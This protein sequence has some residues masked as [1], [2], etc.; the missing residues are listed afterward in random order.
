MASKIQRRDHR[1]ALD[2]ED[3]SA[4]TE[5]S[6]LLASL[7]R[8]ES[9]AARSLASRLTKR[10]PR[11]GVPWKVLGALLW[12]E[13]RVPEALAAM[14]KSA[15]LLP[16]DAEAL[17]NLGTSLSKLDRFQEAEAR[18]REAID[19][20]PTFATAHYRLGMN[21]SLQGLLPEAVT[22]LRTG[23]ALRSRYA[24]GDDAQ[25]HSNLLFILS[26]LHS[27]HPQK[28]FEEHCGFAD[29]FE[30]RAAW[31][32]HANDR[33]AGRRLKIGFVSG[34]FREHAVSYFFQPVVAH[35]ATSSHVELHAY[36]NSAVVDAVTCRL[37][38]HFRHW[39]DV[40][41][42]TDTE[43]ADRIV[44]DRIDIL[45]D[46]AGHTSLNRL[47]VFARKPAPLQISWI[48]YPGTT[49]L[50]AM[51]YY[52]ADRHWLPAARFSRSF[53]EKLAYLPDRWAF[54]PH[55]EAP[56]VSTLPALASGRL[57]FG[58]FNRAEKIG[59]ATVL[60]WSRLLR[61]MP[62]TR[63]VVGGIRLESQR[64]A[65][66][67]AF[68]AAGIAA[69]RLT[70]HRPGNMSTHL[71][72]HRLVDLCLDTTP[73]NGGTTTLHALSMGV[74]TLTLAGDTPMAH[75]GAGILENLQLGA[76]VAADTD[77]FLAK[78]RY[79]SDHLDELAAIRLGMRARLR[80]S[81]VGR[82]DL[83]ASHVEGALRHMWTRWC[84]NLP[85]ESFDSSA[86][87]P[88]G[89]MAPVPTDASKLDAACAKAMELQLAGHPD[90]AGRLY[91]AVL[92]VAPEHAAA[93]YCLG[94]IHV[95]AR[96]LEEG[97]RYLKTAL[98]AQLDVSDYWLG[99]LEALIL[100]GR[101]EAARGIL[102]VGRQQG[103]AGPAVDEFSRRLEAALDLQCREQES[104]LQSLFDRRDHTGA[105][106]LARRITARFPERGLAWKLLGAL[107]SHGDDPETVTVM[108]TAARLLPQDVEAQVNV[109][110]ALAKNACFEE[111]EAYLRAALKLEP[112]FAATYYRLAIT[113]EL[114]G[115][116]ADA[117]VCLRRGI[118][119]RSGY[120][121]RE[122]EQCHSNLLFLMA[123]NPSVRVDELVAEH[124]R[125]GEYFE[126]P[127]RAAWPR[128][129]NRRDP[130][131]RLKIGF[132]SGDLYEHSVA[133]FIGPILARLKDRPG[134]E[135][136]VYYTNTL[137]DEVSR[138]LQGF[139]DHWNPIRDLSDVELTAKIVNDGIDVL[140]DLSGHTR[141]NRLSVFARKPAP[142]Q[143]SWLGYPGTTGLQAMDYYLTDVHWL[144]RGRFDRLFSEKLAYLPA[145]WAFEP[146]TYAPE[147]GPLPALGTGH[148][149]FGSFHRMEKISPE[150]QRLWAQLLLALPQSKLL[151]VGIGLERQ[152][153]SLRQSFASQ[154]IAI[155]RMTFHDRCPMD[156]YL[157]MHNHVDIALD[158]QPYSGATTTMHSLS[159]G[160]P[161]FTVPGASSQARACAGILENVGLENFIAADAA[162]LI[163]R[164]RRWADSLPE[165]AELRSGLRDR[166]RSSPSGRPAF[167]AAHL[168]AALRHMWI[169]W[170]FG[171]PV[172]SF[173]TDELET[174]PTC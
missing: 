93:N 154:G 162:E 40:S 166:L 30:N 94:M 121:S 111:A 4:D 133:N 65:L 161:T 134:V 146:H 53:T 15:A 77:D 14:Q 74:P 64:R 95:Q 20:D 119:L 49:G 91:E 107:L 63:M 116:F 46:L 16:A 138:R 12:A 104:A 5:E 71:S 128:H 8:G 103:L 85:A 120:A 13:G 26:H 150:T 114:Q 36:S 9:L 170:C 100:A 32:Q 55:S 17:C 83:I 109:G 127:L 78:V 136:H 92:G 1:P 151:L 168:E 27:T 145:R 70:F 19:I 157:E 174:A 73:Y 122:D 34:D 88:P 69:E 135:L 125:F 37:Q 147:V 160:V 118:A 66:S 28:L 137:I 87:C 48:G 144:P 110:L 39:Q 23:I 139:C 172:E 50:R 130:Q 124:R 153:D 75:A 67:A 44:A 11:R 164:A 82:P 140:I 51:D 42:L 21:Y 22:C 57:T 126:R 84:A 131:R 141:F 47:P 171:L 61:D 24:A 148:L 33:D 52:F 117:E 60:L 81:P 149:T 80:D 68:E 156:A 89:D 72:L 7:A 54:E 97:L 62:E 79:W 58:S 108:R 113:Y 35:L 45:I 163:G 169:Q 142:V 38:G 158:A 159:M 59:E 123:H 96:R 155:E 31:P 152:R 29:N 143:V 90:L 115:R 101:I 18:L 86:V 129:G 41:A 112:S 25:N 105:L 167:I 43:L 173:A 132:V 102:A 99:Y 10:F 2:V 76:F 98:Q 56:S 3:A 6:T 165:L 106:A